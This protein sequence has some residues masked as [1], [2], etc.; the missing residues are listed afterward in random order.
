MDN[1]VNF[2]KKCWLQRIKDIVTC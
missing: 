2:E 1:Q